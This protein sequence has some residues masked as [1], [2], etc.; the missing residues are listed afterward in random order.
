[1]GRKCFL[2][3]M[4]LRS[5][6]N[7]RNPVPGWRLEDPRGCSPSITYSFG[8]YRRTGAAGTG[9]KATK[10]EEKVELSR[11]VRLCGD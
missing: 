6:K 10:S 7:S 3:T 9:P 2:G 1:M 5:G 11:T 4:I 8:V